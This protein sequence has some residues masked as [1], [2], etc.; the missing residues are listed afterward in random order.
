MTIDDLSSVMFLSKRENQGVL[1][2]E[3]ASRLQQARLDYRCINELYSKLAR[4]GIRCN[5]PQRTTIRFVCGMKN[6]KAIRP[7]PI[8]GS[9]PSRSWS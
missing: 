6:D 3:A 1:Y 5:R 7:F 8:Q 9:S 4:Q 2:L